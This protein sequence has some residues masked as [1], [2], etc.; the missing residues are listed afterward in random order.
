MKRAE[1]MSHVQSLQALDLIIDDIF[2]EISQSGK[3]LDQ[4]LND[5]KNRQSLDSSVIHLN[6]LKGIFTLLEMKAAKQLLTEITFLIENLEKRPKDIHARILE[7]VSTGMLK[8]HRYL[9]H[10]KQKPVDIPELLIPT[11]NSLR[12]ISKRK[13]LEESSFFSTNVNNKRKGKDL[14]LLTSESSASESR[15]YRKMY[16]IGLI[17]VIRKTNIKGGLKMMQNALVK[18]DNKCPRPSSPNLWWIAKTLFHCFIDNKLQMSKSRIKIFSRL[19]RQ[20]GGIENKNKSLY[21]NSKI[22]LDALAKEMLYLGWISHSDNQYVIS[23]LQHF[24]LASSP[25]S[26]RDLRKEF[27]ELGGPSA[28]DFGSI[29]DAIIKE[30]SLIKS[31]LAVARLADYKPLDL[32]PAMKQMRSL[33]NM[34]SILKVDDQI[35]R[36]SM[37]IELIEKSINKKEKLPTKDIN[38]LHVVIENIEKSIGQK[39]LVKY[40]GKRATTRLQLSD[41]QSEFRKRN[42]QIVKKIIANI[43]QF[44]NEGKKVLL[45]KDVDGLF[46]ELK[47]GFLN[48]GE[49]Q[50]AGIIDKSQHFLVNHLQKKPKSTSDEQ[51]N[52]F[53]DVVGSL[54]FYLETLEFT[55]KPSERILAFAESSIEKLF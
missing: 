16:Q 24:S 9:E 46:A 13:A 4:Y 25:M 8:L 54:E 49:V 11:I 28:H 50:A 43:T 30:L 18:L 12:A 32:E 37:A 31:S 14:V 6:K 2:N 41:I 35:I 53:A 47:T 19:D 36:L 55:A 40:S 21:H 22:E 17:E 15:H 1:S 20:I 10:L 39:E 3:L 48:L 42:H 51:I 27:I 52:L 7:I 29:A 44:S 23:M 33:N 45:L 5:M 26:D 38:I 34:L